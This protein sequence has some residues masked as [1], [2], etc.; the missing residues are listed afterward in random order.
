MNDRYDELQR[1][2]VRYGEVVDKI[3]RRHRVRRATAGRW[4]SEMV[5]FLDRCDESATMLSPTKQVDKAWHEFILFTR[6]YEA[7]CQKRYGRFIH[8]TPFTARDRRRRASAAGVNSWWGGWPIGGGCGGSD[9][10]SDGGGGGDGGSCGGGSC[11]GGGC[12]GGGG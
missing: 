2:V 4:F 10:G 11:G 9:G 6:D 7:F 8:H 1:L 5:E 12:G 3:A